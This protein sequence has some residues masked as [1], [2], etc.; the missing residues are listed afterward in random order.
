MRIL[1]SLFRGYRV[2]TLYT[3]Q[4][5]PCPLCEQA[6]LALA[7]VQRE[8]P[9]ILETVA[10]DVPGNEEWLKCYQYDIPVLHID[11]KYLMKHKIQEDILRHSLKSLT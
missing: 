7:K 3:K 8:I 5:E 2:L 4:R 11:G 1:K 9:F 10:I 6:K